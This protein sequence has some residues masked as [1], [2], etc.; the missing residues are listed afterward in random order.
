MLVSEPL[1][2]ASAGKYN[3]SQFKRIA[4]AK[5]K[6]GGARRGDGRP[7]KTLEQ[8]RASRTLRWRC[9]APLFRQVSGLNAAGVTPPSSPG[10]RPDLEPM[11]DGFGKPGLLLTTRLPTNDDDDR[12]A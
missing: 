3:I 5:F 11:P 7:P 12:T 4:V 9:H 2:N 6:H 1:E 8:L 10:D